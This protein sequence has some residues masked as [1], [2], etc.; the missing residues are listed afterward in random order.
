MNKTP[1]GEGAEGRILVLGLDG[2][3][4]NLLQ[5]LAKRGMLPNIGWLIQEGC[6]SPL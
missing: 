5:P 6:L 2:A 3:T 1:H 4:L